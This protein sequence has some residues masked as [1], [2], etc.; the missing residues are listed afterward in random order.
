MSDASS[1]TPFIT[2]GDVTSDAFITLQEASVHCDVSTEACTI[3]MRWGIR[4][5]TKM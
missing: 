5:H 2:L 3:T 4:Y 1:I